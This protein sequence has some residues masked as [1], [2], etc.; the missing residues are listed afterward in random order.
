MKLWRHNS[1]IEY[2]TSLFV[3]RRKVLALSKAIRSEEMELK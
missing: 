2:C 3:Y 1:G